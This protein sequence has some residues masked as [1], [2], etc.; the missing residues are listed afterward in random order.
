MASL[1][2]PP[3]ASAH[4]DAADA[5]SSSP[6]P[7]PRRIPSWRH[8]RR[9][10]IEIDLHLP[11]CGLRP[12]KVLI[13]SFWIS[14]AGLFLIRLATAVTTATEV[15]VFSIAGAVAAFLPWLLL[16]LSSAAITVL[17]ETG[18]C[19]LTWIFSGSG[20]GP[21][22]EEPCLVSGQGDDDRD[23][24]GT[25]GGEASYAIVSSTMGTDASTFST[26]QREPRL[27]GIGG[28][29]ASY[30]IVSCTMGTDASTSSTTQREPSLVSGQCD[31][32]RD[33]EGEGSGGGEARYGIVSYTTGTEASLSSG[34]RSEPQLISGP[35]DED[36]DD[37][38]ECSGGGEMSYGISSSTAG[39]EASTS[40]A[41][42][43]AVLP[44][45]V[46]SA[47]PV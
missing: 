36:R 17:L 32:D 29:E 30:G 4:G 13:H 47:L 38:G 11:R 8:S 15:R 14:L 37:E 25:G 44:E 12:S 19:D 2:Q 16:F 43:P 42:P 41:T 31:G 39:S 20:G 21:P 23:G 3:P 46:E 27:V 10:R 40:S 9:L 26:T 18:V 33:D 22:G 7:P 6:P 35:G 28:G 34:T 1:E 24:D 5:S 45:S